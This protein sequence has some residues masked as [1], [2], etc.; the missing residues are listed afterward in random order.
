M[1]GDHSNII[2][3]QWNEDS[4]EDA[5]A[6]LQPYET[7]FHPIKMQLQYVWQSIYSLLEL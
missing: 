4:R 1:F 5:V 3:S 7:S 6:P 2:L